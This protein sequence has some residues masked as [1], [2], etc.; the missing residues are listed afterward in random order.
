MS[1]LTRFA[2]PITALILC[3]CATESHR[4][5]E[6]DSVATYGWLSTVTRPLAEAGNYVFPVAVVDELLRQNGMQTPGEMHTVP[7]DKVREIIGADASLAGLLIGPY[8]PRYAEDQKLR[9]DEL[10]AQ[11]AEAAATDGQ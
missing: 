11:E 10:A 7:L 5:L 3:A 9:R 2:L 1:H 8:H 6:T 4:T